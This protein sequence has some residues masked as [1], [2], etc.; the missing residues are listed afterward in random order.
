MPFVEAFIT[1]GK[2]ISVYNY[3]QLNKQKTAFQ[4][5]YNKKWNDTRGS[6]GQTVDFLLSPTMPHAAVPH[7]T[8]RWLGYTKVWNALD[9]PA[10]SFPAGTVRKDLDTGVDRDY[11]PRNEHDA[12]NWRLFDPL[13]LDGHPIG[14][15]IIGRRLEEEQLMG[16]ASVIDRL[17][18]Q[19]DNAAVNSP[20]K[21]RSPALLG[22]SLHSTV[23]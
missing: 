1:R 18:K 13:K 6:N 21:Q 20:S 5:A 19:T 2:P 4:Q 23:E 9:Y 8:C 22:P 11:E 3:W 14:L 7:R 10:L 15:Q 17:L 12:W 16:A